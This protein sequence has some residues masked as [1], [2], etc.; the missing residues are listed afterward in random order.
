MNIIGTD[1]SKKKLDYVL[2]TEGSP[3]KELY[4][5]AAK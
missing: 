2:L 4:G 3:D 1:V 5:K